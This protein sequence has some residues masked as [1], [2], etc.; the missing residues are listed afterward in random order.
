MRDILA[1]SLCAPECTPNAKFPDRASKCIE[2]GFVFENFLFADH[3][4]GKI[5]RGH[6]FEIDRTF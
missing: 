6:P 4:E 1:A 3:A 5:M 2:A